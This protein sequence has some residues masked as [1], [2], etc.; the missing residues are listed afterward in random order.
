M[1]GQRNLRVM[2]WLVALMV[3]TVLAALAAATYVGYFA[4][5]PVTAV[6][7]IERHGRNKVIFLS[8]D[9]GFN[10][11]M[12]PKIARGIA[13]SGIPVLGFN[14]L[15]YFRRTRSPAQ[16]SDIIRKLLQRA[17]REFGP[18]PTILVGQSFGADALQLGLANATPAE[19]AKVQLVVL[20]VPTD[21]IYLRAS[22]NEML[23]FGRPDLPALQ[24]ADEL[25]W[26]PLLCIHGEDE[27]H[28]LCPLLKGRNVQVVTLPGGHFLD[29][30]V[31]KVIDAILD[32]IATKK[33]VV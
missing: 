1:T 13:A 33:A 2:N 6:P 4:S 17:D 21:G 28:S 16:I 7:A 32:S 31:D 24:T 22:P 19:R 30:N 15:T 18:G 14:S 5:D 29:G 10:I 3:L 8:G 25:N 27:A 23:N 11:G 20:V 12:G 9:M 26:V